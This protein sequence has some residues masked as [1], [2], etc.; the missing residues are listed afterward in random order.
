M[1]IVIAVI[2]KEPTET[3]H[4]RQPRDA[5]TGCLHRPLVQPADDHCGPIAHEHF[6]GGFPCQD[7]RHVQD[8]I[9]EIR[10]IFCRLD[11]QINKTVRRHV[12]RD[13]QLNAGIGELNFRAA[14]IS[15]GI[16]YTPAT[17]DQRFSIIQGGDLRIRDDFTASGIF[18]G[19]ELE[20]Q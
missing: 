20:I 5:G 17:L 10:F 4:I 11:L 7:G 18:Q 9:G 3:R 6:R 15:S 13:P 8:R 2:P 14:V 1:C 12:R 16:R 19:R